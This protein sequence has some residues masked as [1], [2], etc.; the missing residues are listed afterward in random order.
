[1]L[2]TVTSLTQD[3]YYGGNET[4]KNPFHASQLVEVFERAAVKE[5]FRL[6]RNSRWD[7]ANVA[8]FTVD[9]NVPFP[10]MQGIIDQATEATGLVVFVAVAK[11]I[12]GNRILDYPMEKAAVA[13]RNEAIL[14]SKRAY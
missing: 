4:A 2:H 6:S 12:L 1:M 13:V 9:E 10:V 7:G 8:S 14:A 3:E 5:G 11:D